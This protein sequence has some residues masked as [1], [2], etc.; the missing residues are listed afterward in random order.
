MIVKISLII[1]AVFI[2]ACTS[3]DDVDS[4]ISED[5]EEIS[6]KIDDG[7]NGGDDWTKTPLL[8]I[9]H[10]LGPEY[11][12]EGHHT[13]IFEQYEN[14]SSLTVIVT[15]EGLLDD[16]VAGEKRII[17]FVYINEKWTIVSMK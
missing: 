2:G 4:F 5:I 13:F 9:N 3:K 7:R 1:F 10:L 15:S 6:K 17:E 14:D 8:I 11:N 16:S 12:S